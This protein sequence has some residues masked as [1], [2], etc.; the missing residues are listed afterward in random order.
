M[1]PYQPRHISM[2]KSEDIIVLLY[3]QGNNKYFF[4][5]FD[6]LGKILDNGKLPTC[7]ANTCKF[8]ENEFGDLCM[9]TWLGRPQL[10]SMD[11]NMSVF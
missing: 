11:E 6:K 3:S 7:E 1:A 9:L 8:S 10:S 5:K 4:L 2:S